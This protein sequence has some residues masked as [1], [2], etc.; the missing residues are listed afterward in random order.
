MRTSAHIKG[1]A[2]ADSTRFVPKTAPAEWSSMLEIGPSSALKP[3]PYSGWAA[4]TP[5]ASTSRP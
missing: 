4:F 3:P 2:S 5:Q 1:G